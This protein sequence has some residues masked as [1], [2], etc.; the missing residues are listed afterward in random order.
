M[1]ESYRGCYEYL[2]AQYPEVGGYE[3]YKDHDAASLGLADDKVEVEIGAGGRAEQHELL[4]GR[5]RGGGLVHVGGGHDGHGAETF[6]D[7]AADTARRDAAVGY[8]YG[9]AL[10]L[11]L[12]LFHGL[13]RHRSFSEERGLALPWEQRASEIAFHSEFCFEAKRAGRGHAVDCA[14]TRDSCHSVVFRAG[15]SQRDAAAAEG[16]MFLSQSWPP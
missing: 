2:S 14:F 10:E 16:E 11:G 5:G 4:S 12:Y 7:G 15:I 13:S 9:F 8:E 1:T 6:A 3:F